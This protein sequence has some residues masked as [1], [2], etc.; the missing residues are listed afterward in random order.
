MKTVLI[1]LN[2]HAGASGAGDRITQLDQLLKRSGL[3]VEIEAD[4]GRFADRAVQL[5]AAGGLEAVVSAGGDGTA[6]A[7]INRLSPEV[8]VVLFPLG[9]ENLLGRWLG[10]KSTPQGVHDT[11]VGRRILRLDAASAN[12]RLFLLMLGAGFDASVVQRAHELRRGHINRWHYSRPIFESLRRYRFPELRLTCT[13]AGPAAEVVTRQARW[14]FVF[15]L[16]CYAAG[17]PLAPQADGS[18]GALDLT[19][20]RRGSIWHGLRYLGSVILRRHH[21]LTD[22]AT[23]RVTRLRIESDDLV[24]YQVDGDPGGVLP[25][26]IDVLPGRLS[27]LAPPQ[28]SSLP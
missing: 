18:D 7:V 6:A 10:Q 22:H 20:F 4:L 12:G 21:R 11:I 9:T 17:L 19:T 27:L 24:P 1:A 28:P 2:P 16:P 5:Q 23:L 13:L 26:D 14:A 3:R 15:N 8:P 25:V